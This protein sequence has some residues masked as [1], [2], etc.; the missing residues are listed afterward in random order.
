[1]LSA[2][3]VAERKFNLP[4]ERAP[5]EAPGWPPELAPRPLE[6]RLDIGLKGRKSEIA[7]QVQRA[8]A[9]EYI[10][11]YPTEYVKC[12]MDGS[13]MEGISD[14]GYGVYIEWKSQ[15][16]SRISGPIGHRTCCFECEKAA[17]HECIRLLKERHDRGAQFP[18]AVIFCDCRSLV[19]NLGGFNPTNMGNIMS[20][21]EQLRQAD[22]RIICQWIPSH[23]GIHGNEVADELAN[24]GRLQPKPEVTATLAHVSSLLRGETAKRW[25]ATISR[26]DDPRLAKLYE[27]RRA[28][29]TRGDAVQ[30]FHLCVNHALL[31][32]CMSKRGWG[33]TASYCLC[34]HRVEDVDHVLFNCPALED[35]R[36]PG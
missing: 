18:G 34:E 17:L 32:V 27:A 29:D 16:T 8:A 6:V 9:L 30:V 24:A 10:D 2:A 23:V 11:S 31:L 26:Y 5:L 21:P 19:Q 3:E 7:P 25:K 4:T 35:C 28:G 1:M 33:Q 14:G 12:Y 22:V 15:E 36:S 13:A 20:I